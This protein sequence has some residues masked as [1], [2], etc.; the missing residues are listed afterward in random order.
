MKGKCNQIE[1][2]LNVIK[3]HREKQPECCF[4]CVKP[5]ELH[6]RFQVGDKTEAIIEGLIRKVQGI[7]QQYEFLGFEFRGVER[8]EKTGEIS[9]I[10][11][12]PKE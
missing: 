10:F 2:Y 7:I 6:E 3:R 8:D 5:L 12:P 11:K 1:G 4:D 9:L